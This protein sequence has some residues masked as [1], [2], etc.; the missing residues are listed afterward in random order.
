[1]YEMRLYILNTTKPYSDDEDGY[2]G[3]WFSCP[4]TFEEIKDKLGV[5]K[6]EDFE[7]EDFDLPLS[8]A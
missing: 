4:V 8:H 5:E 7:I 1:M 3:A 2:A 6:E